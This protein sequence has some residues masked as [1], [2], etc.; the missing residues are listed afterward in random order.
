MSDMQL[1]PIRLARWAACVRRSHVGAKSALTDLF[2]D[3]VQAFFPQWSRRSGRSGPASC[4][5]FAV[6]TATRSEALPLREFVPGS[7]QV[8]GSALALRSVR[9]NRNS[10]RGLPMWAARCLA[11]RPP[12]SP[13]W[14]PTRSRPRAGW[15]RR[16]QAGM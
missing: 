4:E 13:S 12:I 5:H 16:H 10:K 11:G 7:K 6:T 1:V 2:A 15:F 8:P 14:S 9:R 3:Q